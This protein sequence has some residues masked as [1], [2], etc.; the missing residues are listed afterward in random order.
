MLRQSSGREHPATASDN[1][2][3]PQLQKKKKEV[4]TTDT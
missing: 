1:V 2:Y 3:V 4:Q